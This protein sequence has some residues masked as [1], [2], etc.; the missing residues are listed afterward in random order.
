MFSDILQAQDYW[1]IDPYVRDVIDEDIRRELNNFGQNDFET[2]KGKRGKSSQQQTLNNLKFNGNDTKFKYLWGEESNLD[3]D[4]E[5]QERKKRDKE[6]Q[7]VEPNRYKV[8]GYINDPGSKLKNRPVMRMSDLYLPKNARVRRLINKIF[9]MNI[10]GK[11]ES[12]KT[13]EGGVLISKSASN[14]QELQQILKNY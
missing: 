7:L 1:E 12:Q 2:G 6:M 14:V 8:L 11:S 3:Y 13:H 9:E 10:Y 4:Y 5:E